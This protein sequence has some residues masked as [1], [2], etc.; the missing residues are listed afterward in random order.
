[1]KDIKS[2]CV[3]CGH[4]E[5]K[6]IFQKA[7]RELGAILAEAGL[8]LVYGGEKLG[9]MGT[10]ADAVIHNGGRAIGF[11]PHHLENF[12]SPHPGIQEL[13]RVD[14]M[15]TRKLQM[16]KRA[17]AFVLLPGGFG[18]LDEFF[19]IITWKQLG[20]HDKPIIIVNVG[21]YWSILLELMEQVF[22]HGFAPP[23]DRNIFSIVTRVKD[24]V[25]MLRAT[26]EPLYTFVGDVI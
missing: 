1:M 11:I 12:E 7:A 5:S 10:L 19:E 25:P 6:E 15:H 17:D 24:V 14:T 2:V 8:E 13:Y 21:D 9:L 4:Y 3:Y 23:E 20:L 22:D 26:Q 16:S 18:T